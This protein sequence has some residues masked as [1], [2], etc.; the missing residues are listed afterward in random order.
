[1][2]SHEKGRGLSGPTDILKTIQTMKY[3]K[4]ILA[5]LI[6]LNFAFSHEHIDA[7]TKNNGMELTLY[8]VFDWETIYTPTYEAYAAYT[9]STP[10]EDS[11]NALLGAGYSYIYE[12]TFTSL[13]LYSEDPVA[14]G[15]PSSLLSPLGAKSGA[16]LQLQLVGFSGPGTFG[17]WDGDNNTT[18]PTWSV[19]EA[20]DLMEMILLIDLT[21]VTYWDPSHPGNPSLQEQLPDISSPFGHIHG[22]RYGVTEAGLYQLTW[23]VVDREG[24][25][26]P[27]GEFTLSFHAIPE[28][29]VWVLLAFGCAGLVL[30]HKR[31]FTR[32][33]SS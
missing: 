4:L 27:S 28:P 9:E 11:I 26:N 19:S 30:W 10:N 7:G 20:T 6:P 1:M 16:F 24:I 32:L 13:H 18:T 12:V 15:V 22:R 25:Y 2:N 21:N 5:F 17:F 8:N 23:R 3:L 33:G 29:L 14:E 31:S